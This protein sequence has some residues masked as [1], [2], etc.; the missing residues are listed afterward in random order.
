[1]LE[2][3]GKTVTKIFGK[4]SDRDLKKLLPYVETIN[5]AWQQLTGLSDDELRDKTQEVKDTIDG[6]LKEIDDKLADLRQKAE[7]DASLTINEKNDIF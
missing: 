6:K 2:F 1:M 7:E 5:N 4:K 3:V